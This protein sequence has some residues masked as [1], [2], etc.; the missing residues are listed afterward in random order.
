MALTIS[1]FPLANNAIF[2]SD[3]HKC[4]CLRYFRQTQSFRVELNSIRYPKYSSLSTKLSRNGWT[5][6]NGNARK[7]IRCTRECAAHSHTQQGKRRRNAIKA[8]HNN[9]HF[10]FEHVWSLMNFNSA[11]ILC[12]PI[13]RFVLRT[14]QSRQQ[15]N[16]LREKKNKL[17]PQIEVAACNV[18]L[19]MKNQRNWKSTILFNHA[20]SHSYVRAMT[21]QHSYSQSS[22]RITYGYCCIHA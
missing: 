13:Y 7:S 2:T 9:Y 14:M 11:P 1:F 10:H 6:T 20:P 17:R 5:A 3:G 21:I 19:R 18:T 22:L 4:L 8:N 15:I 12:L 16:M